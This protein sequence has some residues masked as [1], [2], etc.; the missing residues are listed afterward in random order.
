M[1]KQWCDVELYRQ[2][3]TYSHQQQLAGVKRENMVKRGGGE[4]RELLLPAED[5]VN[6]SFSGTVNCLKSL[7]HTDVDSVVIR[8]SESGA[9]FSLVFL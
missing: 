5:Q 6:Q 1:V 4:V 3:L 9:H 8:R 7:R 2:W